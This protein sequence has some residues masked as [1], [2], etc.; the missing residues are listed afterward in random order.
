MYGYFNNLVSSAET[1]SQD[2]LQTLF[3]RILALLNRHTF[4]ASSKKC[5]C[6]RR[7]E[8]KQIVKYGE[9]KNGKRGTDNR[10]NKSPKACVMCAF[11]IMGQS[12]GEVLGAGQPTVKMIFH[13]F[14]G[15]V[16]PDSV[17]LSDRALAMK[18]FFEEKDDLTVGFFDSASIFSSAS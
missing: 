13:A 5:E 3:F 1:L 16:A 14:E 7:C 8:S 11:E 18:S 12:Y 4:G 6:C 9:D 15:R 2:E 10:S 17:V